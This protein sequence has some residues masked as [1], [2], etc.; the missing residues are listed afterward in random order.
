MT[1]NREAARSSNVS[2]NGSLP[3]IFF[4]VGETLLHAPPSWHAV[5]AEVCAQRGRPVP[6]ERIAAAEPAV[7]RAVRA[8]LH[9]LP[10]R[11]TLSR[12]ASQRFW[13]WVYDRVLA[14]A[15][16]S[17]AERAGLAEACLER[18]LHHDTWHLFPDA[19]PVIKQLHAQGYRMGIISNWEDWLEALLVKREIAAYFDPVVISGAVGYEK[20]EREIFELALTRAG[21]KPAEAIHIGDSL[22]A[23]VAGARSAGITPVLLDRLGR[24]HGTAVDC[25][26]I[27]SLQ[28][29]P[30]L[31]C[32]LRGA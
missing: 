1:M 6:A 8:G 12:E 13:L 16:L 9:D 10:Q 27:T 14:E 22:E 17:D 20:P 30:A 29:L 4:D 24:Y 5:V 31:L 28:E 2:L 32:V 21:V 26:R 19:L 15:G 25:A 11:W 7:W 18:F 3:F 23:D